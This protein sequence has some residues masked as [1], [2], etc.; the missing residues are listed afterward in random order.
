LAIT[1]GS[2]PVNLII[3]ISVGKVVLQFGVPELVNG[4]NSAQQSD[5]VSIV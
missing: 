5:A 1:A 3:A 4:T 2:A